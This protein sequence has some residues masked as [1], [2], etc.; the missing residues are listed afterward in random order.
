MLRWVECTAGAAGRAESR[1]LG[2]DTALIGCV[3][4]DSGAGDEAFGGAEAGRGD[5]EAGRGGSEATAGALCAG[6]TTSSGTVT[7]GCTTGAGAG[8]A[9]GSV[10]SA[11][12][13]GSVL[14]GSEIGGNPI[15]SV[16]G[17]GSGSEATWMLGAATAVGML[18][19]AGKDPAAASLGGESER[20][21]PSGALFTTYRIFC[22]GSTA[23]YPF[24]SSS[25]ENF[26]SGAE[27]PRRL[28]AS[29]SAACHCLASRQYFSMGALSPTR[30]TSMNQRIVNRLSGGLATSVGTRR[31]PSRVGK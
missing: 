24:S 14:S 23:R 2:C 5:A 16:V 25:M 20:V 1:G 22:A 27:S 8:A 13:I 26:E 7:V 31:A 11:A 3:V 29:C 30:D 28:R 17:T 19:G 21:A 9:I 12:A 18:L 15:G 4:L 6:G 10:F